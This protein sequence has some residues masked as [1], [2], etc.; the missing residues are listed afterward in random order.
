MALTD[1]VRRQLFAVLRK[2][3]IEEDQ[4]HDLI[5][6]YTEGRT[7]S[8]SKMW[9]S[10]ARRLIA[11]LQMEFNPQNADFLKGDPMRKKVIGLFRS[12]GKEEKGKAD[13]DY[14]NKWVEEKGPFKK[15][16]NKH[17]NQE[18]PKLIAQVEKVYEWW[19]K[20]VNKVE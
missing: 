15:P 3:G 5:H 1:K 6:Q 8:T 18:L 19:I 7:N 16:L 2:A 13:M 20:Q 12:M 14:I 4:R 11:N 17:T 9:D 10:E